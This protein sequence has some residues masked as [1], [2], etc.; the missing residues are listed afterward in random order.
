MS[1]GSAKTP[2]IIAGVFGLVVCLI[3]AWWILQRGEEIATLRGHR[4]VVRS[5]AFSPDGSRIASA[6]DDGVVCLWDATTNQLIHQGQGHRGR[7]YGV[8]FSPSLPLLASVGEDGTVRL[9]DASTGADKGSLQVSSKALE[10]LTF[11]PDGSTLAAAGVDRVIHVRSVAGDSLPTRDLVGHSKH[12]HGLAFGRDRKTLISAGEV[13]GLKIWDWTTGSL[14]A[15]ADLGRGHIHQLRTA[16]DGS[17]LAIAMS[18]SGVR[19]W[20]IAERRDLGPLPGAGMAW[21]VDFSPDGQRLA[22]AHEDGSVKILSASGE[23]IKKFRG[24]KGTATSVAFAPDGKSI[25]S[26]GGDGLVKRWPVP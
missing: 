17:R 5:V 24:H 8:V 26:G 14:T 9:W 23:T 21:S 6:G 13:D 12:V 4:A 18:G 2:F 15:K 22:T 3:A 7:V 10:C 25:V 11:A 16:P 20:S 19:L 1:E